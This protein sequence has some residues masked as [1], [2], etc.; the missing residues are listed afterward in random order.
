MTQHADILDP[1]NNQRDPMSRAFVGALALH[2]TL[3]A[4]V[5][6]YNWVNLQRDSFGAKDAGGGAI[7]VEAVSSIPIPRNGAANPL[8]HD[9]ESQV[10]Q[11]PSKPIERAQREK[12]SPNAIPLKVKEKKRLVDVASE[13]Q[14]F[15]NFKEIDQN[16]VFASQA[17]QVSNPLFA[18]T[19]GSGRIGTGANTTLGTRFAGYAS[20]IQQL[21]AQK[22]HTTDVDARVQSAPEV[23]ATFELMRDGR[24]R[25]LKI[26]Q[27]SGVS[28]L[29]YSVQRAILEA[30]PFPPIPA[31]FDRDSA[32]VE[33]W[34]ELKR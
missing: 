29:D 6:V 13:R 7:G 11:Q 30:S 5:G 28:T 18:A 15:R 21:I 32:R 22:W 20:Q 19:P 9:T 10:P 12:E 34:F 27:T 16:Q 31:G 2:V 4:T 14:R 8:A 26:V 23:I 3:I 24:V 33:F 25:N 1:I 17:P